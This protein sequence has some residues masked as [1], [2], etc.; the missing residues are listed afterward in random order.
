MAVQ[1][2]S[3][4]LST[5]PA[6][7]KPEV[8]T[9]LLGLSGPSSSGKTTLARLLRT[10]FNTTSSTVDQPCTLSLF[11]LHQD[12]FYLTD[13]LIPVITVSSEEFGTRDLQDWDC[14][15]SLDLQLFADTLR[16]IRAHW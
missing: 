3:T 7:D 2:H 6:E 9:I 16:H 8:T 10:I 11:I 14:V 1:E 4:S 5:T 12:D 15:E 13:A